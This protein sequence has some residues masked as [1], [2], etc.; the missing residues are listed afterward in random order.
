LT[1]ATDHP[2]N[3]ARAR[4]NSTLCTGQANRTAQSRFAFCSAAQRSAMRF[5]HFITFQNAGLVE[6]G[7]R[8]ARI[9]TTAFHS[10]MTEHAPPHVSA[11]PSASRVFVTRETMDDRMSEVNGRDLRRDIGDVERN[12]RTGSLVLSCLWPCVLD[13][14][15]T[16]NTA[17]PRLCHHSHAKP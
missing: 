16:R 8:A 10:C 17:K 4:R 2:T 9:D 3:L 15:F 11:V 6:G 5:Q 12:E 14:C 1:T 7:H 13:L